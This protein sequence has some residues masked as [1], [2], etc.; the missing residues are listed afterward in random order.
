MESSGLAEIPEEDDKP[1]TKMLEELK[2]KEAPPLEKGTG[3]ADTKTEPLEKGTGAAKTEPLEKGTGAAKTE[4][5]EKGQESAASSAAAPPLEKGKVLVDY[6]G[7]LFV[8]NT[9]PASS[10]QAIMLLKEEGYTPVICSFCYARRQREV[11]DHLDKYEILRDLQREFTNDRHGQNN[12]ANIGLRL[13][14]ME[15][16]DDGADLL[17]AAHKAGLRIYP[18]RREQEAHLWWSRQGCKVHDDLLKA[19][20]YFLNDINMHP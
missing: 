10:L 19:V 11:E 5:L 12:K 1:F 3:S 8:D 20:Q 2:L 13:G 9:I 7:V 4:P 18:I 6:Y 17:Q 14:A 15:M 16:F